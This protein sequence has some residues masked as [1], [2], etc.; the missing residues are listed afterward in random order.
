MLFVQILM[1]PLSDF[2]TWSVHC[3]EFSVYTIVLSTIS[4]DFIVGFCIYIHF[5]FMLCCVSRDIQEACFS[6]RSLSLDSHLNRLSIS[7]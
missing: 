5:A 4:G 7:S 6:F 1:N 3:H 2:N